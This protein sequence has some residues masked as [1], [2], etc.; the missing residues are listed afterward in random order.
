M[1]LIKQSLNDDS[2]HV[3]AMAAWI[4]YRGGDRQ[5]AQACWNELLA[6][7]SYASLKILNIIDWIGEGSEPYV[8][9]MTQCKFSHQG[10]VPRML[11]NLGVA[12]PQKKKKK[13]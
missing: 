3:R 8:D 6:S 1:D 5:T 9:A 4:L 13:K 11:E 12:Q 10:Y 2:H 7:S